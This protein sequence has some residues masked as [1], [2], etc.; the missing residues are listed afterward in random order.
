MEI[1]IL[2]SGTLCSGNER[3][4]ACYLLHNRDEFALLDC[5]PGCIKQLNET[6]MNLMK[7]TTIFLS[8]FHLDHCAD[9]LPLLM[10]RYLRDKRA[11]LSLKIVGPAGLVNWFS[12]LASV[13]GQWLQE[14]YP[15]IK[16]IEGKSM[17]WN[18]YQVDV[19][20]TLHSMHCIAYR[21][22]AEKSFFYSADTGYYPPLIA[23]AKNADLGLVE[24]SFPD[25]KEIS[26]HLT[27]SGAGQFAKDAAIKKLVLTH[28]Y[29]ENDRDDLARKVGSI[30][31]GEVIVAEDFMKIEL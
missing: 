21:F 20:P 13:Q 17:Q 10:A 6:G 4:P 15:E 16:E 27:P 30:F 31:E 25:E 8:H 24:C 7:I 11:N 19:H 28:I 22:S 9:V 1:K 5:G 2:G 23:F 14:A 3:N 26:T 18:D 12:V 29:P